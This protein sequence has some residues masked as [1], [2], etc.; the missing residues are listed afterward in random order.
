LSVCRW[1]CG[2]NSYRMQEFIARFGEPP[3]AGGKGGKG[4]VGSM[5]G[6]GGKGG[7]GS[8]GG[9]GGKCGK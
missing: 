3:K 8:M 6:K 4:G 5:G 9:K 2:F 1:V 7:V